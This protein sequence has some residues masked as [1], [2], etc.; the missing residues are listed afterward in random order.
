MYSTDVPP[1]DATAPVRMAV[2]LGFIV[3]ALLVR[4]ATCRY[5]CVDMCIYQLTKVRGAA[6]APSDAEAIS[7]GLGSPQCLVRAW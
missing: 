1:T 2:H 7:V 3:L 6:T 4:P 5:V